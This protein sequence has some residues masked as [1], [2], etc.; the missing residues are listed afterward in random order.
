[1]LHSIY[2]S[3][4]EFLGDALVDDETLSRDAGL[5]VVDETRLN[6]HLDGLLHVGAWHDD[7]RVAAAEFQHGLLDL[8]SCFAGY[9]TPRRFAAGQRDGLDARV[10]DDPLHGA[11]SD[12]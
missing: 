9:L 2:E 8:L 3:A 4:L 6:R 11:R 7:E 1:M 5:P 10:I 12:Q